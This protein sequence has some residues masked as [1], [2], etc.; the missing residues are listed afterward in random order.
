MKKM[1]FVNGH[2][3][4]NQLPAGALLTLWFFLKVGEEREREMFL[5]MISMCPWSA[6]EAL[7]RLSL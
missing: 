5:I 4:I 3:R 7:L 6:T 1:L 2:F